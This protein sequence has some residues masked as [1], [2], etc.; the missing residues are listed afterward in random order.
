MAAMQSHAATGLRAWLIRFAEPHIL[1]PV[2]TILVLG[3]IWGATFNLIRHE[4]TNAETAAAASGLELVNTYDAQIVRALREIDQTLKFVKYVYPIKGAHAALSELKEKALL[5]PD[6]LFVVSVLNSDGAVVASTRSAEPAPALDQQSLQV[7]SSSDTIWVSRPQKSRVSREW[8]LQFSRR[9]NAADGRFSGIVMVSVDA[10][11]FVSGYE[12][13]KLGEHGVLGILGTDGVFRARRTG[14]SVMAGD[15]VH[16]ATAVPGAD[17][18]DPTVSLSV[19]TWDGVRRYTG[20]QQ[21]YDF[22]LAVIV[23]LSEDEQLAA[24]NRNMRVYLWRAAIGSG[25]LVLLS[26]C[27]AA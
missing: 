27:W 7:L 13:S 22:P 5:P 26:P 18:E 2:L 10:A 6:L 4:R 20:A 15:T 21:L 25:L 16:Y 8:T 12:S 17:Q 1:F 11:Y 3:G 23:G 14:N 24:V 9:L 19:N